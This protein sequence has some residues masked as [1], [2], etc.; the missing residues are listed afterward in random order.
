[1]S[2][3]IRTGSVVQ[4]KRDKV[5]QFFWWEDGK[6]RSKTLGRFPT[7]ATA[8]KASKPLRD[9]LEVRPQPASVPTV[10]TLVEHYR[11]E[12]MPRRKDTRRSYEVWIKQHIIPE[13]GECPL[14]NLQAR[15]VELWL[16]PLHLAP[17]SKRTSVDSSVCFGILQ[18][19]AGT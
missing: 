7:K 14:S 8:W 18:C 5:W 16:D 4:D 1:M 2:S 13:W 17:K 11:K 10:N 12:K 9:A 3:R 19:G 15:P 6:R